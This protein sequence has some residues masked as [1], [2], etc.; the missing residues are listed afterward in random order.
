[1]T[2]S[3]E[4]ISA[5]CEA[6]ASRT[7]DIKTLI[8][9]LSSVESWTGSS[10]PGGPLTPYDFR[11]RRAGSEYGERLKAIEERFLA[12]P[13]LNSQVSVRVVTC[14]KIY[15][16]DESEFASM[17]VSAWEGRRFKPLADWKLDLITPTVHARDAS[18]FVKRVIM[19]T[20][21][22]NDEAQ[23]EYEDDED[24]KQEIQEDTDQAKGEAS[25]DG[26]EE[27]SSD[28]VEAADE[29][30]VEKQP[31]VEETSNGV[32]VEDGGDREAEEAADDQDGAAEQQQAA[33]EGADQTDAQSPEDG[34]ALK[35][36]VPPPV[37][38]PRG[39]F[40]AFTFAMDASKNSMREILN[41]VFEEM[42][43]TSFIEVTAFCSH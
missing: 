29:N 2:A 20:L 1:M 22:P 18:R 39:G 25:V 7:L 31:P 6:V 41:A 8:V 17:F 4:E 14:G 40:T 38:R 34:K 42:S 33:D 43:H 36:I 5:I 3:D 28:Q 32:A 11:K 24:I 26:A 37:K 19:R 13:S 30:L 35:P 27:T 16:N 23:D 10:L 15:G 12:L 21:Q 9:L